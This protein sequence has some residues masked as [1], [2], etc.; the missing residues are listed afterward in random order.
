MSNINLIFFILIFFLLGFIFY[1]LK[2]F[3]F[4]DNSKFILNLLFYELDGIY[5]K[6]KVDKLSSFEKNK[7]INREKEILYTLEQFFGKNLKKQ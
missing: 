1:K 6:L 4:T 3:N 5:L 7:L 2:K